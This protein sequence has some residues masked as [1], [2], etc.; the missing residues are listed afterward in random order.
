MKF[1]IEKCAMLVIK[2]GKQHPT[3]RMKLPNQEKIRTLRE[4]NPIN[5][6]KYWK[7]APSN[8]GR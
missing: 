8:K 2:S 5:T 4:R 1:G 7:L 6:W 3:D